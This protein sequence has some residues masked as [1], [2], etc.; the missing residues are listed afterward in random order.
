MRSF[1]FVLGFLAGLSGAVA[2]PRENR[3]AAMGEF[4]FYVLS[5][6]WSAT[7]CELTGA[8]RGARQ[9]EPGRNPGFVVHGLWPQYERGYPAFCGPDGRNP[10]RAAMNRAETVL[11]DQG[12][13]RH[14]WRK[15]G[16]CSGLPPEAYFDATAAARTRVKVPEKLIAPREN[17]RLAP[18]DIERAFADV[19]PGLRADMMSVTCDRG[20]LEEIRI[21]FTKDL[22]GFRSCE[23]VDRDSCRAREITV[24]SAR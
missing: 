2:Q 11:P 3:G 18:L 7:W 8:R 22:R 19:N 10:S 9:C 21:C 6:S 17:T 20:M 13:A 4:D 15:H 24:P 14:Q 5:L 12:L 23:Q 16:S 1:L